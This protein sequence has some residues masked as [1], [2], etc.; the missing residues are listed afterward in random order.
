MSQAPPPLRRIDGPILL[1][2]LGLL[3]F[4]SPLAGW[5]AQ[6]PVPWYF[7]FLLWALLIAAIFGY[8]RSRQRDDD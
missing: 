4:V 7:P 8:Q 5:W 1:L 6:A 3:L 2:L